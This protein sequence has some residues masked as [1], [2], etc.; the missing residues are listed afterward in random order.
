MSLNADSEH[1]TLNSTETLKDVLKNKDGLA[2]CLPKE[3]PLYWD[4]TSATFCREDDHLNPPWAGCVTTARKRQEAHEN[5]QDVNANSATDLL[6][7]F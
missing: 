6:T 1:G 5:Y 3:P 2:C 4:S 7:I